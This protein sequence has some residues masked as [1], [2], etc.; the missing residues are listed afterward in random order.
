MNY[1]QRNRRENRNSRYMKGL[2]FGILLVL[3]FSFFF[4][5]LGSGPFRYLVSPFWKGK[6]NVSEE[7][8]APLFSTKRKLIA[9]NESLKAEL[10]AQR[11]SF[12]LFKELEDENERL[13]EILSALSGRKSVL[14]EVLARPPVSL[15]D[16]FVINRGASQIS[17]GQKV[18]AAGRIP[19]G[20]VVE[21][22][23]NTSLIR[24]NSS[25]GNRFQAVLQNSGEG[26]EVFGAGGGNYQIRVPK[27]VEVSVGESVL[28]QGRSELLGIV[29]SIE[30]KETDSFKVLFV[31]SPI[32][33]YK[34]KEVQVLI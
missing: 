27:S 32:N 11:T 8:V 19:I 10:L 12:L 20:E 18:L 33:I 1:L 7:V 28:M 2:V 29:R 23:Q 6:T 34:I 22:D 21:V 5:N 3:V 15:Y 16:T 4:P 17:V 25:S 24:L 14:A 30:E 26:V 31:Q 9:E 13:R